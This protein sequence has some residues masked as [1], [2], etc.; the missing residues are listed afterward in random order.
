M[1]GQLKGLLYLQTF[2][3]KYSFKIF[4]SI[5]IGSNLISVVIAALMP[6]DDVG[7]MVVYSVAIYIFAMFIGFRHVNKNVNYALKLGATRKNIFVGTGIFF[8]GFS[9]INAIL[10]TALQEV[11]TFLTSV[12]HIKGFEILHPAQ[13]L[14]DTWL[15]RFI[16][17]TSTTFFCLSLLFLFGLMFYKYGLIGGGSVAAAFVIAYL[18]LLGIGWLQDIVRSIAGAFSMEFFFYTILVGFTFYL[19]SWL[20]LRRITI[21]IKQ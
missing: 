3:G 11:I 4:W 21:L 17:D 8:L 12:F 19:I 18:F 1:G 2:N 10:I 5:L 9:V 14:T 7:M 15:N 13:L 20:F 16:I 6:T